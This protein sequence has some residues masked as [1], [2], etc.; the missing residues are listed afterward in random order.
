MIAPVPRRARLDRQAR[1]AL[2]RRALAARRASSS[3]RS[4]AL[5][6][7]HLLRRGRRA[8][9]A[10]ARRRA[11][12]VEPRRPP[13]PKHARRAARGLRLVAYRP[14]FSGP[15][16]E[17]TPELQFQRRGGEVELARGGRA[18]PR[19][20]P[21]ATPSTCQLERHV[22][23]RC[24]RGSRATSPP[25]PCASRSER[26]RG[27]ARRRRGDE[28]TRIA[29]AWWIALI[30]ALVIVNLVMVVVRLHDLARAQAARPHAA[31]LRPE[32]RRPVRAAAADRRPGE[33]RP[34]GGVLPCLAR[35]SCPT[36]SRRSSRASTAL[37]AFASFPGAAAGRSTATTSPAQVAN[38]PISLILIFALGSIGIYG[39]IVGGWAS[40]SKYSMLG[41]MRTCAQLVSY[42][43]SLALS[44]LGVVLMGQLAEPRRHRRRSSRR[45]SGSSSRS[46][47]GSAS[48]CSAA[49]AETSRA[50]V[51]PARGRHRARRRL[52]HRV[53]GHALGPLPD[54][55][56]HQHDRPLRPRGRRSSSTAG[57]SRGCRRST[58]SGRSGSC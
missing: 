19:R 29:R 8:G 52:P 45:R 40:D 11:A 50:A 43:V 31:A 55:R 38:V 54:G 10:A 17:R 32:P 27:P 44:V 23:R 49:I 48:S 5:L 1:R 26:R 22:G 25:A 15:A 24:A 7:R 12:H 18:R 57:T 30:K 21:P 16:V 9:A 46:S 36:S 28:V 56:V 6:R 42:E 4:P 41:S 35:T 47:S 20:S 37:A 53:L 14:L 58:A 39:F 13:A 3:T 51:R 34:Q 33:A 2:R